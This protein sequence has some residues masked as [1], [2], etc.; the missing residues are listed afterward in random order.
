MITLFVTG[1]SHKNAP[2]ALR[3]QLAV[4]EDKLREL[5]RDVQ[6][7]GAVEEALILSTCNRVEVYGVAEVPGEARAVAFH[8][9]CR[10]R[11]ID[12]GTVDPLLYTHLD[13]DAVLHAFRVASSLD[14]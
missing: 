5:L 10:Y 9:L 7:T 8:R 3:E 11:G 12:P 2:V 13:T 1:L 14:S 6:A 4:E